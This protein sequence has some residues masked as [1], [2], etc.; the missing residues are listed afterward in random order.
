[1]AQP[2]PRRIAVLTS[3]GDAQ[4][5]NAAVRA[6]AVTTKPLLRAATAMPICSGCCAPSRTP[7]PLPRATRLGSRSCTMADSPPG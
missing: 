5:L 1:M 3:G 2:V 4:G 6:V 7:A